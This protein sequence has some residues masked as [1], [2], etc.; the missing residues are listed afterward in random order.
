MYQRKI[1]E[2]HFYEKNIEDNSDSEQSDVETNATTYTYT[3]APISQKLLDEIS[4]ILKNIIK[5]KKTNF[6][7]ESEKIFYHPKVPEI[8]IYDYLYRIKKYSLIEDSTLIIS[9]IYIDRV[10]NNKGII[11]TKYNIHRILFSAIF[12]ALKFN[13]DIFYK[14][15]F[16]AKIGG[17]STK[18]LINLEN[19]FIKLIDF[20]FFVSEEIFKTYSR[21]LKSYNKRNNN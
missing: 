3:I 19:A 11:L 5:N 4:F 10:C 9:L 8:S 15:S 17:I 12:V 14:T 6:P 20:K 1:K 16:Y 13:E 7:K 18:E 2:F 21:Y